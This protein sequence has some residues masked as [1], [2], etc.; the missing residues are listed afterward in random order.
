MG[1][2]LRWLSRCKVHTRFCLG[3]SASLVD[4]CGWIASVVQDEEGLL[5]K[6]RCGHISHNIVIVMITFIVARMVIPI[7]SSHNG[8]YSHQNT[9][10]LFRLNPQP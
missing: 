9:C 2:C 3:G 6:Y 7:M 8:P 1:R 10:D 5:A 4:S